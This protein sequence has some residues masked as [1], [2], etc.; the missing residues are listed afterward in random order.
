MPKFNAT[1]GRVVIQGSGKSNT[2]F[3]YSGGG[4]QFVTSVASAGEYEIRD[5]SVE[6]TKLDTSPTSNQIAVTAQNG[7]TLRLYNILVRGIQDSPT[8]KTLNVISSQGGEVAL[9]EGVEI[10]VEERQPMG[11]TYLLSANSGGTVSI[12][13]NI[14]MNGKCTTA[15]R[16]TNG[17]LLRTNALPNPIVSGDVIGRR[18][19]V[20][21]NSIINTSG[22][23]SNY[24]PGTIAGTLATGGQYA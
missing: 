24:F 21:L 7:T 17:S 22:G 4:N 13:G 15:A 19:A 14:S 9:Y 23:G 5:V 16:A 2:L 20:D 12:L 10:I 1:T 6:F 18:Y 8:P 3:S 11:G